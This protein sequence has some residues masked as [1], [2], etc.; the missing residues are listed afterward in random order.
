MVAGLGFGYLFLR[1]G[2]GAAILAHF[3]N[4]YAL[5]L[6]YE[7]IGGVGPE[8]LISLLFIGLAIAGARVLLWYVIDAWRHL[9]GL[10]ARV[11]PPTP[12][13]TLPPPT[14]LSTPLPPPLPGAP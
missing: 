6:A 2:V 4:D 1:H 7:G 9:I 11:R 8:T 10:V 3:V 13:P 14:P 12:G 5:S